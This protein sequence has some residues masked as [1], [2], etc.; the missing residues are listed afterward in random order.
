MLVTTSLPLSCQQTS[1]AICSKIYN[2]FSV[3]FSVCQ[4][5]QRSDQS[6]NCPRECCRILVGTSDKEHWTTISILW[7]EWRWLLLHTTHGTTQ[8]AFNRDNRTRYI[9]L[10]TL[11]QN[12]L[13]FGLVYY[14][15]SSFQIV[16]FQLTQEYMPTHCPKPHIICDCAF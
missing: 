5:C 10:A 15:M 9:I 3:L 2:K 7:K 12:F 8:Y 13:Y 11:L 16:S 6:R 1:G 14:Q 4:R